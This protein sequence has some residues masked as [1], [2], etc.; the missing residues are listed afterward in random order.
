M[1]EMNN[2]ELTLALIREHVN[3]YNEQTKELQKLHRVKVKAAIEDWKNKEARFK[4]GDVVCTPN[5]GVIIRIESV[6]GK[7]D[8]VEG[9]APL[10]VNYVGKRLNKDLTQHEQYGPVN[11]PDKQNTLILYK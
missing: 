11:L 4:P 2:T 1:N 3:H 7:M 10:Y 5:K 6:E 9:H 8:R